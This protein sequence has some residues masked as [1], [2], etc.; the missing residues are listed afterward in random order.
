MCVCVCVC[1]HLL[2]YNCYASGYR[3]ICVCT[4]IHVSAYVTCDTEMYLSRRVRVSVCDNRLSIV[5]RAHA[6]VVAVSCTFGAYAADMLV[7]APVTCACVRGCVRV[8]VCVCVCVC[9][10]V[11]LCMC[12]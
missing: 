12:E 11:C 4:S 7:R 3:Y 1:V 6:F 2:I 5:C 9:L 8:C 10:C